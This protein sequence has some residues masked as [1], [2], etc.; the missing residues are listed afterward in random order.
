MPRCGT[1]CYLCDLPIRIDSYEGCSHGCKYCFAKKFAD[2]SKI[3]LGEKPEK[4][5]QFIEGKRPKECNWCDWNIPLHWGGMSDPFQPCEKIHKV[6][7][8]Y[9]KILKETQ[10]PF[11][12]STKGKLIIEEPYLTLLS[13]CNCV[14]QISMICDKYD[15]MEEGAPTFEERLNMLKVLSGKVKRTIVRVQPYMHEVYEDVY[16]NLERFKE[17]GAYGVIIEGM[18][19][20]SK[21]AGLVKVGGDLTYPYKLILSDF[22]KLKKRAHELGLKIYAGENRIRKYGDSLTC[23][24]IDGLE[25][26]KPNTFNLNHLLNGDTD[27]KATAKQQEFGTGECFAS[28]VQATVKGRELRAQSFAYDMLKYYKDNKSKIDKA[29]GVTQDD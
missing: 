9:L 3:S 13:E 7:L 24:G 16:N 15:K 25:D 4:L 29:M 27:V 20:K 2:I 22:V 23:C 21:K 19:F 8:E 5:K 28:L 1:Q 12:V 14:V 26:F 6:S 10:Y 18:K 11:I 17:A